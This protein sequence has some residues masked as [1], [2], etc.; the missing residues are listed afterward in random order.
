MAR[1]E[2]WR[3]R[4]YCVDFVLP[5]HLKKARIEHLHYR[6]ELQLHGYPASLGGSLHIFDPI[7]RGQGVDFV[8]A[9]KDLDSGRA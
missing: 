3:E 1:P 9:L 7:D 5:W 8:V 4:K 6:K 2:S